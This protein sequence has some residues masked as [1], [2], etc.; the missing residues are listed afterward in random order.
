MA[1]PQITTNS[2]SGAAASQ[3]NSNISNGQQSMTSQKQWYSNKINLTG[4]KQI[5]TNVLKP[6]L[7]NLSATQGTNIGSGQGGIPPKNMNIKRIRE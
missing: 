6:A 1:I 4:I 3:G 5:A 7:S 2:F